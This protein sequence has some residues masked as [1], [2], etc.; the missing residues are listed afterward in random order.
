MYERGVTEGGLNLYSTSYPDHGR[1]RNLPLEGKIPTAGMGIEPGTSWL[2]VRGPDHQA[3][4]LVS[5]YMQCSKNDKVMLE[6]HFIFDLLTC[7]GQVGVPQWVLC[8]V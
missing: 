5:F 7:C 8:L 4:R 6:F 1:Y 3:K 2:V